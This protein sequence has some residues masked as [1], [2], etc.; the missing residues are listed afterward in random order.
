M[1]IDDRFDAPADAVER[2]LPAAPAAAAPDNG[3]GAALSR[4]ADAACRQ[5][6]IAREPVRLAVRIGVLR[7]ARRYG[8]D[9]MDPHAYHNDAHAL[10]L[11]ERTLPALVAAGPLDAGAREVLALFC[12]CHDLRQRERG[13]GVGP[14][15]ANEAASI[16]EAERLLAA[17]GLEDRR[18]R[19][20]LR[21]AIAGSTFAAGDID[22]DGDDA[23]RG[24]F[25]HRLAAWLDDHRP[26]WRGDD[27]AV[28]AERVARI[29]AD[30][31]TGAIGA[32]YAE[33]AAQAAALAV[34]LQAR[35]GRA[36]D[37]AA[38]AASCLAFLGSGQ[39]RYVETLHRF[40][41]PEGRA[42]FGTQR[43]HNARRAIETARRLA[44]RFP[45]PPRDGHT[46]L[47]AFADI[48]DAA[49]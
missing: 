48:A 32:P 28:E 25:A 6:G 15:G 44:E 20:A 4:R 10:G 21:L 9:G 2:A 19:L 43:D 39:Q 41:S 8:R 18:L 46:V 40:A 26:G 7:M 38:A 12:A 24:A 5:L 49:R 14:V 30:V 34:E 17:L 3:A 42:A 33:F 29:A 11:L 27:D 47:A 35:A 31:D 23:A 13:P 36:L 1:P 45:H 37:G 22:V 16:A